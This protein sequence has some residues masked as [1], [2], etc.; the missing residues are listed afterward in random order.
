MC[1]RES[2]GMCGVKVRV[3]LVLPRNEQQQSHSARDLICEI[4][5]MH[6]KK[7]SFIIHNIS[8]IP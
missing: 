8:H 1:V 2:V 4:E 3:A 7:V 6:A 5:R